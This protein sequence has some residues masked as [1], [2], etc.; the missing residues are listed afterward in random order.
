V[1]VSLLAVTDARVSWWHLGRSSSGF[2]WSEGYHSRSGCPSL[3]CGVKAAEGVDLSDLPAT[4]VILDGKTSGRI[5][6]PSK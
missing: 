5:A 1:V 4:L 6:T 2:G 3:E